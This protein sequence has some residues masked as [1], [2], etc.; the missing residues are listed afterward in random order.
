[1]AL[2]STFVTVSSSSFI[3]VSSMFSRCIRSSAICIFSPLT[4]SPSILF[5]ELSDCSR[6]RLRPSREACRR[7]ASA[8]RRMRTSLWVVSRPPAREALSSCSLAS[9]SFSTAV[10]RTSPSS[11]ASFWLCSSFCIRKSG[12]S[13][14]V[15]RLLTMSLRDCFCAPSS[16]VTVFSI[17]FISFC[18]RSTTTPRVEV[19]TASAFWTFVYSSL[20]MTCFSSSNSSKRASC[21]STFLSCAP[22]PSRRATFSSSRWCCKSLSR[23][24]RFLRRILVGGPEGTSSGLS[25]G[26]VMRGSGVLTRVYV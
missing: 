8:L 12:S 26:R 14:W 15:R 3:S 20:R 21:S 6:D 1:M 17:I 5:M 4:I 10:R 13:I 11:R 22:Q 23:V 18:L 25:F 19:S 24:L 16:V 9:S 7:A 2:P